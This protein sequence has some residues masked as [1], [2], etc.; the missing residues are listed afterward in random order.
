MSGYRSGSFVYIVKLAT[1]VEA[2]FLK[3]ST[4]ILASLLKGVVQLPAVDKHHLNQ[5]D[6]AINIATGHRNQYKFDST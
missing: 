6:T 4:F 3:S 1:T 2:F 5:R